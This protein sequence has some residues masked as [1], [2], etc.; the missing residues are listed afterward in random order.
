[1]NDPS[2]EF[3]LRYAMHVTCK[4]DIGVYSKR[5]CIW[6]LMKSFGMAQIGSSA[7]GMDPALYI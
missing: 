7:F 1:M 3:N 2:K 6:C 5:L 4:L